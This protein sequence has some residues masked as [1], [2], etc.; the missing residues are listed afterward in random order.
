MHPS[1]GLDGSFE[2]WRELSA[3]RLNSGTAGQTIGVIRRLP[4]C[5]PSCVPSLL[6]WDAATSVRPVGDSTGSCVTR[7]NGVP[8]S[9]SIVIPSHNRPDL[10]HECLRT[11]TEYA[12][13]GTEILVVDDGSAESKV[14]QA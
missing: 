13:P 4:T 8:P 12:P 7:S 14:K 1:T 6:T 5:L 2:S 10:L 3:W 9:L 11:L